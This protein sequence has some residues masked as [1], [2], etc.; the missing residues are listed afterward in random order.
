[1]HIMPLPYF[2]LLITSF[3]LVSPLQPCQRFSPNGGDCTE[4]GQARTQA[5]VSV[6]GAEQ[7]I[8]EA[9]AA[10]TRQISHDG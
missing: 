3:Y 6:D 8:Q 4:K 2:I 9:T 7:F 1:M 5:R 10:Q